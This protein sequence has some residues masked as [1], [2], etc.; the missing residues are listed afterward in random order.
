[1]SRLT[2]TLRNVFFAGAGAIIPLT[3]GG[4]LLNDGSEL[5]PT[6]SDTATL[7]DITVS[8]GVTPTYSWAVGAVMQLTI[9]NVRTPDQPVWGL[10]AAAD[11]IDPPVVHGTTKAGANVVGVGAD[12]VNGETYRVQIQKV[13]SERFTA[14]FTVPRGTANLAPVINRALAS[15]QP[16]AGSES[17]LVA[18]GAD[19]ITSWGSGQTEGSSVPGLKDVVRAAA[20]ANHNLAVTAR[21][22]VWAWGENAYGQL[23]DGST[24]DAA[25]P[26][27]VSGLPRIS[28]VA[29]GARHSLALA[30]DG[31]VWAWGDNAAGQLGTGVPNGSMAPVQVVGLKEVRT[32][33]AGA[34]HSVAVTADGEV[35]TWGANERG[36]LGTGS[37]QPSSVPTRVLAAP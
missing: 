15:L 9:V 14:E 12:L 32:I 8:T 1:M 23:G 2:S 30:S 35:W 33:S 18:A 17:T 7:N 22:E 13:N 34:A 20:G 28:E 21:G 27:R 31:T 36:Q 6:E 26:V 5:I 37:V 11:I 4:C 3:L 10:T 16:V 25:D 29:A 19:G 24:R